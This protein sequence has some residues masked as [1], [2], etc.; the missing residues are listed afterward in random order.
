MVNLKSNRKNQEK[1]TK[2]YDTRIVKYI[3]FC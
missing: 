1:I 2:M 3:N